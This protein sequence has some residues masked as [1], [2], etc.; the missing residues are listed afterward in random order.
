VNQNICSS[1]LNDPIMMAIHFFVLLLLWFPFFLFL[2]L[3]NKK[4]LIT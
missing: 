1:D 2:K 3:N 4:Y